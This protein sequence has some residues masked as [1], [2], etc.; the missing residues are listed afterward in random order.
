VH[1]F[2]GEY[3]NP[4][5]EAALKCGPLV[6]KRLLQVLP[7]NRDHPDLFPRYVRVLSLSG[8]DEVELHYKADGISGWFRN[9]AVAIDRDRLAVSF[10]DISRRKRAEEQLALVTAEFRHRIKNTLTVVDGIVVQTAKYATD[11]PNLSKGL[12]ARLWA[13]AAAQDLL[14]DDGEPD[15]PLSG[16]IRAALGPFDGK[17]LRC[18]INDEATV[19]SDA[20]VPLTLALHELATNAIKYGA[21]SSAAGT[22]EI[23]CVVNAGRVMLTWRET[24]GKPAAVPQYQGFGSRLIDAVAHRLPRGRV[25]KDFTARGLQVVL[26]F[27]SAADGASPAGN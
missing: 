20:V 4:A 12:R 15:V 11:V 13:L 26:E 10:E 8:P 5:A 9:C 14:K 21:L 1:R 6:G 24:G 27:D 17:N 3:A 2:C 19:A 16:V 22:A 18:A 23:T 7:G 25:S